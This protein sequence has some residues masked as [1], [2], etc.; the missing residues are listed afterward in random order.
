MTETNQNAVPHTKKHFYNFAALYAIIV[1]PVTFVFIL[2]FI[3]VYSPL[4]VPAWVADLIFGS[5]FAMGVV[6][7]F[8]K[9]F[10]DAV[11][12]L[13]VMSMLMSFVCGGLALYLALLTAYFSGL[14]C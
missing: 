6:S 10:G 14:R 12:G 13:V 3:E 11:R 8:D 7:L 4:T 5:S 2:W 1:P 9:S